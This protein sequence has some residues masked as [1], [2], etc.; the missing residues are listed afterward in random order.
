MSSGLK[1]IRICV[2]QGN[3]PQEFKWD[4]EAKDYILE[5]YL[6]I[7]RNVNK[8]KPDLIIWPEA[9]LPVVLEKEPIFIEQVKKLAKEIKISI[10]LGAVNVQDN[11]FPGARRG[12]S[13]SVVSINTGARRGV[14]FKPRASAPS[15]G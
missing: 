15:M 9:A 1:I 13:F 7:T 8:D 4:P 2:I 14:S 6:N 5:K 12:L 11:L 3:I 10:L